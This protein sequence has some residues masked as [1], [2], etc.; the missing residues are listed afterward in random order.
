MKKDYILPLIFLL[1]LLVNMS[2]AQTSGLLTGTL[3]DEKGN[4]VGYS[5]VAILQG[6]NAAVVTG[7]I[8]DGDG[9]FSIKTP[10][11]GRY[12]LR[13]S[14][15]GYTQTDTAPFEVTSA[16]FSKDFGNLLLK[17]DTKMLK[18]V[19]VQAMR[20]TVTNHAD[21]MVV[22]VEN[23]ALAAGSTIYE[24]LAKS[25]G[26]FI[27][28]D[29]NIQLNG[30]A[31]VRIMIDG[32]LTYLSG[33]DLQSLLQ[34]MTAENL[35]DLEIITNPSAKYDAEGTSGIIN[36]NLKKNT[37]SGM[38][39][40]IYGGGQ[41]NGM[42][43][44]SNGGNINYKKGKWNSFANLDIAR[45]TNL[46]I[47]TMTREFNSETSSVSFDQ[48]GREEGIRFLP[49][50]RLGTDFDINKKHSIG[51]MANLMHFQADNKFVTSTYLSNGIAA[52]DSLIRS[53]N[54]INGSFNNGTFNAHYLGKLDS[55]GTTI[56]ADLDYVIMADNRNTRF[57]NLSKQINEAGE[58]NLDVSTSKNIPNYHIYSAKVDFAKPFSKTTKLEAGL[59]ASHVVSDNDLRFY[60]LTENNTEVVDNRRTNHFIYTE[61]V[62]AAYS[63]FN[64]SFGDKWSVQAGLR[65]EQTNAE[66]RSVTKNTTNPFNYLNLFPSV[67]V[68]QKVN[69]DYQ[70]TYNYSRRIS[71]PRY[72]A[73]NPF[74]FF[75]D[76]Y[77]YAQGNP[78]LKPQY[79]DA[80]QVTQTIK[81][82]YNLS[83]SYN[84]TT[85][86][87]AEIPEQFV[88]TNTTIFM[89]RNVD[90]FKNV[91]ATLVA[92]IKV[93]PKWDINNNVTIAHQNYTIKMNDQA[94]RN[95]Q[96][97]FYAQA[98]N[99]IM[100]PNKVR[101]EL[102]VGYQGPNAYGLYKIGANWG[103][104][105]GVKRT[106]LNDQLDLSLN[107]TDVFRTRRVI[108]KANYN[109]NI[110]EFNQYFGQQS[111]R[112]NLR[113]KFNKGAK[114]EAKKR[115]NS[116]EELNR[117][118]GN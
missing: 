67:F 108:G 64:T 27:D 47:N 8:T 28:Q 36:L 21:K 97:F 116:L 68:S 61:N 82:V 53:T 37:I 11:A 66:G 69:K 109:G 99:N 4:A 110:N 63:N 23:T 32:K 70:L 40:S 31:G 54:L 48:S 117:A 86:F 10:A 35:K 91:S 74:I 3:K 62:F 104:D 96:L 19:V 102:N 33:K 25:P 113:Y 45:R 34:G 118:G 90:K 87:I 12:F 38:N 73:L 65:A 13:L 92:P 71:R 58:G 115:N 95:E 5:T 76:K 14:A 1:T 29:G 107:V 7:G 20:P 88:E 41:F 79:T 111:V 18:E 57:M 26:V 16:T 49:T 78:N 105:L 106:F 15:I 59:K 24:V 101:M 80:F 112:L 89:Q 44:F 55:A 56:S 17:E 52:Q 83:L 94:M 39:G 93:S 51:V 60:N 84:H 72:E 30:K 85:N 6:S 81:G 42:Y 50:L 114:F 9:R 75:L 46:R 100:L 43:G 22:S 2:F 98:T 77:T 103:V